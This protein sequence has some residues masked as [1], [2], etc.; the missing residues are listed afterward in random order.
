[1]I[2]KPFKEFSILFTLKNMVILGIRILQK[3]NIDLYENIF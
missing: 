3:I 1:M 2:L